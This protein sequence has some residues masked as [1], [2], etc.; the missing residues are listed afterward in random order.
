MIELMTVV[1]RDE[2]DCVA[3]RGAAR[4]LAR[5]LGFEYQDQV[6]VATAVS[7]L[8]R[9]A[10]GRGDG[11]GA[12][13]RL[14]LSEEVRP[15]RLVIGVTSPHLADAAT[16]TGSAAGSAL[17][18]ARRLLDDYGRTVRQGD[19]TIAL[20]PPKRLSRCGIRLGTTGAGWLYVSMS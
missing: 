19:D 2:H 11:S 1:L 7:E 16:D 15:Q 14:S 17:I 8:A 6:R 13:A 3:A 5:L 20:P 4:H 18:A 12:A 10:I 9:A